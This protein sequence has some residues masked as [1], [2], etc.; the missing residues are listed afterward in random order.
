MRSPM[1]MVAVGTMAFA[2][3]FSVSQATRPAPAQSADSAVDLPAVALKEWYPPVQEF[4]NRGDVLDDERLDALLAALDET[5]TAEESLT[6]LERSIHPNLQGFFRRIAVPKLSVEQTR[7]VSTYLTD[8]AKRYPEHESFVI[9]QI[10]TLDKY[11]GGTSAPP[12]FAESVESYAYGDVLH[13]EGGYFEDAGIERM[14]AG[15][16]AML[17]LP[18]TV[19][20]F[21]REAGHLLRRFGRRLQHG[22][23]SAEQTEQILSYYD[24]LEEEHLELGETID[25]ARHFVKHLIPGRAAQNIV[26]KDLEGMEFSLEEYRGNIVVLVFSGQWCVPSRSEYPYHRFAMEIYKDDPV[27]FLGINSDADTETILAAKAKG[28]APSY[29]TWWDGHSQ[30]DA[31]VAATNGPIAEAWDVRVWPSTF[32]LD[33]EGVIRHINKLGVEFIGTLDRMVAELSERPL[34]RLPL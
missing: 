26:G 12:P 2:G 1:A 11:A 16:D 10:L 13:P 27:V 7:R 8:L 32:I 4:A 19:N 29:R 3:G 33:Q 30:P 23:V 20:D 21:E 34:G 18:E 28:D 25:K 14:L 17:V 5:M 6:D 9:R 24:A 31:D 22:Q 15:L